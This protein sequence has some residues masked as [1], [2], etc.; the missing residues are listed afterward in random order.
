MSHQRQCYHSYPTGARAFFS[1]NLPSGVTFFTPFTQPSH[2]RTQIPAPAPQTRT[3]FF[4]ICSSGSLKKILTKQLSVLSHMKVIILMITSAPPQA[5]DRIHC[6]RSQPSSGFTLVEIAISI[7]IVCIGFIPLLG[8]LSIGFGS[9]HDSNTDTRSSLIAQKIIAAAQMI[10]YGQ[11]TNQTYLLDLDGN[12]VPATSAVY[13]ATMRV[14][15]LASDNVLNSP[16]AARV[17]VSI[18]GSALKNQERVYTATV[19]NL[20]D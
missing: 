12:T 7:G 9:L 20:G 6:Q 10:P 19:V 5:T 13:R 2:Q 3:W 4:E 17:S 18:T 1:G 8:L 14:T 11:L 15:K 16:N